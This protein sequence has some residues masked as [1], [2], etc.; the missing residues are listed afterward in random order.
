MGYSMDCPF[1]S[2]RPPW[3]I[4]RYDLTGDLSATHAKIM[5]ARRNSSMARS[6]H[7]MKANI[8]QLIQVGCRCG[9][10]RLILR[11]TEFNY[12]ADIGYGR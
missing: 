8:M 12:R 7:T 5:S 3:A 4:S 1:V 11:G 9:A 10:Y 2:W 6:L